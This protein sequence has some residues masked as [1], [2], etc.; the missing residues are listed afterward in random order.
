[1]HVVTD[2]EAPGRRSGPLWI[3]QWLRG[4]RNLWLLSEVSPAILPAGAVASP[5]LA[6]SW[7]RRAS[8]NSRSHCR[9]RCKIF[10]PF[11]TGAATKQLG[12]DPF[13]SNQAAFSPAASTSSQNPRPVGTSRFNVTA[14]DSRAEFPLQT[15]QHAKTAKVSGRWPGLRWRLAAAGPGG[16]GVPQQPR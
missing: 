13:G 14:A 6:S 8:A 2:R 12:A 16:S 1:V 5:L 10:P 4:S 9:A 7:R 15:L 11:R 3:S